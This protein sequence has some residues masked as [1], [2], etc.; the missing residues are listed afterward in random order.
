MEISER[1]ARLHNESIVI[2]GHTDILLSV[3]GGVTSLTDAFPAAEMLA[4]GLMSAA[5]T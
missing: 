4:F 1:A 2:D 5:T 3:I